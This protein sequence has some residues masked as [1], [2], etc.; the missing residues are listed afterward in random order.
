M[1][2]VVTLELA[3]SGRVIEGNTH[4]PFKTVLFEFINDVLF[5]MKQ[6]L[7]SSDISQLS[8][9][10]ERNAQTLVEMYWKM[11]ACSSLLWDRAQGYE[12]GPI[13][14]V[15]NFTALLAF[16]NIGGKCLS[17][18]YTRWGRKWNMDLFGLLSIMHLLGLWVV[19]PKVNKVKNFLRF[20]KFMKRPQT[21]FDTDTMSHSKVIRSKKVKIYR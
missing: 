19:Q 6:H 17:S 18:S 16:F 7:F 20:Q 10:G 4:R 5:V 8:W 13:L 1:W 3:G 14:T 2:V 11:P 15:P 21:T 9:R 12:Q